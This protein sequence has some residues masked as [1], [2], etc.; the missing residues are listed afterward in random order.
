MSE[1]ESLEA[2]PRGEKEHVDDGEPERYRG[3]RAEQ[4]HQDPVV[5]VVLVVHCVVHDVVGHLAVVRRRRPRR[6]IQQQQ[7]VLPLQQQHDAEPGEGAAGA[8]ADPAQV[9]VE[10]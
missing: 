10:L 4:R 3:R 6:P 9:H 7:L 5:V 1:R 2:V 8:A